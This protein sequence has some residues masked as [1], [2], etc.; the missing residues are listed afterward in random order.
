MGYNMFAYCNSN[1]VMHSDPSGMGLEYKAPPTPPEDILDEIYEADLGATTKNYS[2]S[3]SNE[4]YFIHTFSSDMVRKPVYFLFFF[5]IGETSCW[6]SARYFFRIVKPEEEYRHHSSWYRF[7]S[8]VAYRMSY[9]DSA[10]GYGDWRIDIF[11]DAVSFARPLVVK[12]ADWHEKQM[13]K[14]SE[15]YSLRL[16]YVVVTYYENGTPVKTEKIYA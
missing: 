8:E 2:G 15:G 1:P 9:A 16:E 5:K 12:R 14:Y 7:T 10:P 13:K 6:T 11:M 3:S 4:E